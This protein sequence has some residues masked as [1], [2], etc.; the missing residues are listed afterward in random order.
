MKR[1]LIS[2]FKKE[3][4]LPLAECLKNQGWEIISSGG[5]AK[6][7]Q[8]NGIS[9]TEVT[10]VTEFPECFDGRVKTLHPKIHG[11]IL[12]IRDNEDHQK[13]VEELGISSIDLVCVNLYPFE[14]TVKSGADFKDCIEK[15]DIGGPALIRSAAKNFQDVIVLTGKDDYNDVIDKINSGEG[16][17]YE[18]REKLAL[19]AF[20]H[21]SH[22]DTVI[23]NFFKDQLGDDSLGETLT[24]TFTKVQDLRYGENPHQRAGFYKSV[25]DVA[26]TLPMAI[27]LQGKE[28]S[29]N[30]INDTN[31]ALEILKEYSEPTVVA[32]KHT[33]P[34]GIASAESGYEAFV[35]ANEADPTS[36]FGGIIATNTVVDEEMAKAMVPIFLEV[37]VAPDFTDEALEVFKEKPNLRLLKLED[38]TEKPKT[39]EF[40]SVGGGMLIQ[41]S[42]DELID[43]LKVVTDR[44]PTPEEMEDLLF[45]WKAVKNTKSNAISLAK[46]KILIANGPGQV[47]RIWPTENCIAHAGEKAEGSV[48]ASDAFFPFDDCVRAAAEAGITAIIQPGGSVR[49]QD[50]IDV[51]NENGIAMVFTGK[52]HFKHT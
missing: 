21:T 49:D 10:S 52:R 3:G 51:C 34:C 26:G 14:E 36:I 6:Y 45:A 35:R 30:N 28:L 12:N 17:S 24:M 13:Q 39:Y 22:Y 40:K 38:I 15:I 8:D 31:G 29:Y 42:D 41:D 33:N 47:N 9:V 50:S 23:A 18:F 16:V 20:V 5:T 48:L 46:D 32:V 25:E 43:E 11:A 19:K 2:V 37:I 44:E 1:A 7:L 27:Q 4:I